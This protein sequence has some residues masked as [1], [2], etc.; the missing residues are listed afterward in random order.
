MIARQQNGKTI[1][2]LSYA[3]WRD[4]GKQAGWFSSPEE[5]SP[6]GF[7]EAEKDE[8]GRF[9]SKLLRGLPLT[10]TEMQ[11]CEI[12]LLKGLDETSLSQITHVTDF[13]RKRGLEFAAGKA[14][15]DLLASLQPS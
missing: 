3:E 14:L 5:E 7:E 10:D 13:L 4:M 11:R 15:A 9:A 8:L 12:L 6:K 2:S 1:I